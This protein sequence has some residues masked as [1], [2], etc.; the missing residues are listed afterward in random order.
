MA[1]VWSCGG[2]TQSAA[3]AALI[4]S[5]Q[6]PVPDLSVIVDTEREIGYMALLRA[7]AEARSGGSWM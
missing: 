7:G 2:G 6:M 3:I 4:V 5:G 1:T